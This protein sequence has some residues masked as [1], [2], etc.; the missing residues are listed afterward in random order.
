[1]KYSQALLQIAAVTFVTSLVPVDSTST[2]SRI[3]AAARKSLADF[4]TRKKW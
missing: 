3:L 2:T 4:F 1:M